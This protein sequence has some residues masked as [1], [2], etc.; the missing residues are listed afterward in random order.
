MRLLRGRA[1]SPFGAHFLSLGSLVGSLGVSWGFVRSLL[2][3][4]WPLL[5]SLSPLWGSLGTLF[6][7]ILL[8]CGLLG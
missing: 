2:G 4:S 5:L 8:S 3:P 1:P 7:D 6:L